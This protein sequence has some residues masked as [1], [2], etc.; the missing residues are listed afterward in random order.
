MEPPRDAEQ[1]R[2]TDNNPLDRAELDRIT[3]LIIGCA[4]EVH[5]TLKHGFL[6]KVYETAL[7]YEIKKAGLQVQRQHEIK[8]KYKDIVAGEYTSDLLVESCVLVELKAVD[9]LNQI[10]MAQCLNYL[11]A[12]GINVCLLLNFGKSRLEIKRVVHRF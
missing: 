1:R 9:G 8:V 12:S 5:R 2:N 10:H 3:Q 7:T 11:K 6:E 4:Y